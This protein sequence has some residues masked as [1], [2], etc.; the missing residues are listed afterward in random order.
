VLDKEE[1]LGYLVG[2]LFGLPRIPQPFARSVGEAARLRVTKV[3]STIDAAV[4]RLAK[5]SGDGVAAAA[6]E[7][8]ALRNRVVVELPLP[9]RRACAEGSSEPSGE[10]VAPQVP[11]T[12]LTLLADNM[13]TQEQAK[14]A[15]HTLAAAVDASLEATKHQQL[16]VKRARAICE[17]TAPDEPSFKANRARFMA[18]VDLLDPIA[19]QRRMLAT[20]WQEACCA[21][22]R[23]CDEVAAAQER[24]DQFEQEQSCIALACSVTAP[25]A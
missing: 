6:A 5:S 11:H 3:G 22:E 12:P 19:E 24:A 2:D 17:G 9:S 21:Y 18:E 7:L 13:V 1:M 14:K 16:R 4:R 20:Q 15:M 23:A 10:A 8:E 25:V